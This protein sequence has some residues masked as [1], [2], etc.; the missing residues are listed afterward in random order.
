MSTGRA[1]RRVLVVG[2]VMCDV[3]A[4]VSGPVVVGGDTPART[5]LRPGGAGANVAHWLAHLGADV[6]FEGAVGDDV[7]GREAAATL[8]AAG[9]HVRLQVRRGV[10]TGTCVVIVG[11]DAERTMLPDQ[12]ANAVPREPPHLGD[13]AHLHM[14]GYVLHHPVTRDMAADALRAARAAGLTTSLDAASAAPLAAMGGDVFLAAT[15]GVDLATVTRDEAEALVGVRDP[16]RAAQ[17]L[18]DVYGEVVVKLGRDGALL[19]RSHAP[20]IRVPAAVPPGPVAD[21]TGSGDAFMAGLLAARVAGADPAAALRRACAAGA[22]AATVVGAR[23]E[24]GMAT[25]AAPV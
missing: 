10:S 1:P 24:E 5:V 6:A 15:A 9:V 11:A 22:L 7:L 19:A 4:T 2:D 12:G 16:D 25:G 21:T 18:L 13:A 20:W 8:G 17:L 3:V 14:S 23:P